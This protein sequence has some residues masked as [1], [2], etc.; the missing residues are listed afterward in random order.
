MNHS[1]IILA[2]GAIAL[3]IGATAAL[4]K[5]KLQSAANPSIQ[6]NSM[7]S[8]PA[9]TASP[10]PQ[11]PAAVAPSPVPTSATPVQPVASD[12]SSYQAHRITSCGGQEANANFR[13]Y[14]S[15]NA[16][17]VLG[18]VRHGDLIYL[19]GRITSGDGVDW[20]EAI[21]PALFPVPDP[22][23][24]NRTEPNQTGWIAS[25]FVSG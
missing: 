7:L 5:T 19:T 10:I 9:I 17:V 18:A 20:F 4:S 8:N 12:Y 22:G 14:P 16:S 2:G 6:A 24:Q 1:Q 3:V 11:T 25:C 13:A 15:L 21:A 23:A